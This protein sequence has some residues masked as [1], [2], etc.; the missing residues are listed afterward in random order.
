MQTPR[1][2]KLFCVHSQA[3]EPEQAYKKY[4]IE[5]HDKQAHVRI[6]IQKRSAAEWHA[7]LS[8]KRYVRRES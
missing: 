7:T 8:R 1:A 6:T 3:G 2:L 4:K 5:G